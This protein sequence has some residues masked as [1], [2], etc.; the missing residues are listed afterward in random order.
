MPASIDTA[1]VDQ[2]LIMSVEAAA[3]HEP[4]Y[5]VQAEDYQPKLRAMLADGLQVDVI[6][7]SR[8]LE[9]RRQFIADME[10]LSQQCDVLLTPA[11]PSPP[12]ADV[13]NTGDPAFQGPWTSCGLP[14]I[15]L[16]SGIAE[17]GL[18]LGIQL[19]ASPFAEARLLGA[20]AWCENA[21]GVELMPPT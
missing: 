11:A 2:R 8:A 16:P 15:S 14:A 20:A 7:Y 13:T 6:A 9:N 4:M 18:P 21:L 1:Y 10:Q 19:V 17:S 5:R 3:F 12:Q